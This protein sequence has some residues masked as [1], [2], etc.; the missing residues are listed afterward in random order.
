MGTV[1]DF[2]KH[3]ANECMLEM[4]PC[5]NAEHGCSEEMLRADLDRHSYYACFARPVRCKY[6]NAFVPGYTIDTHKKK[7]GDSPAKCTNAGCTVKKLTLGGVEAHKLVCGF[8]DI[9]CPALSCGAWFKRMEMPEHM[10]A[11]VEEHRRGSDRRV[12]E[13]ELEVNALRADNELLKLRATAM[14]YTFAVDV[15]PNSNSENE[16]QSLPYR[17]GHGP[18]GSVVAGY[19]GQDGA[20]LFV[21]F[22]M[23]ASRRPWRVNVRSHH[24]PP[25]V[26]HR[27]SRAAAPINTH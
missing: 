7:C 20:T 11:N 4:L 26:N 1:G 21:A 6:C 18:H 16:A 2:D 23:S 14:K 3:L 22:E 25:A 5:K 10:M 9:E 19:T 24:P 17:F 8:Q 12:K 27:V 15:K 13:L